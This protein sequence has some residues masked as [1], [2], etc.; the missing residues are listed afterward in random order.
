MITNYKI[1]GQI[2]KTKPTTYTQSPIKL[3]TKL[4]AS[5][6]KKKKQISQIDE[7]KIQGKSSINIDI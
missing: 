2:S 7:K 3:K 4:P 1:H 6:E 5:E